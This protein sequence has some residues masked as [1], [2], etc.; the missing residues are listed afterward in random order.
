MADRV[1]QDSDV[2]DWR[3]YVY[4]PVEDIDQSLVRIL[5]AH[6]ADQDQA[7]KWANEWFPT[8]TSRSSE[9]LVSMVKH[10][11]CP[12]TTPPQIRRFLLVDLA[13]QSVFAE[14]APKLGIPGFPFCGAELPENFH[15]RV[16]ARLMELGGRAGR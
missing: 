5:M 14:D 3:L 6:G 4:A 8:V 9:K 13:G 12:P 7:D 2:I 15:Q 16:E 11:P 10:F 1:M